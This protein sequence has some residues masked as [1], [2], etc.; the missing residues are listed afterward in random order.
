MKRHHRFFATLLAGLL[1]SNQA[2]AEK[3][4]AKKKPAPAP[5]VDRRNLTTPDDD[6]EPAPKKKTK[7]DQSDG[8]AELAVLPIKL[9]EIIEAAVQRAPDLAKAKTDRVVAAGEAGYAQRAQAWH[10]GGS[11]EYTRQSQADKTDVAPFATVGEDKLTATLQAGRRLPSGGEVSLQMQVIRDVTEI[12]VPSG[13]GSIYTGQESSDGTTATARKAHATALDATTPTVGDNGDIDHIYGAQAVAG[14]KFK[15]PLLRGLGSDV[16]L[17]DEHKAELGLAVATIKTQLTAEEMI[18]DI[19]HAYWELQYAAFEVETRAEALAMA[20]KQEAFTR[21][22]MRAGVATSTAL[23][24]VL[25]EI[26]TRDEAL[27]RARQALSKQSLDLRRKVGLEIDRRNIVM[28]PQEPVEIGPEEWDAEETIARAHQANRRL[29]TL[30]LQRKAA[31]IDIKVAKDQMLPQLDA[32]LQGGFLGA[33]RDAGG[34][35]NSLTQASGFQVMASLSFDIEASDAA[36][37]G[38]QAAVARKHKIDIDKEDLERQIDVEV[39]N[40]VE[41]VDLARKRVALADKAIVV[42]NDNSQAER[43]TFL[44]NH[45]NNLQVMQRQTQLIESQLKRGRAVADWRNAVCDLQF[46]SGVLLQQYGVSAIPH[47]DPHADR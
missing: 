47:A 5:A 12:N 27:L 15:Q 19:I 41:G 37:Q 36:K 21:E 38:H 8:P 32:T 22:E 16:A 28:R 45:S 42:A 10:L 14:L 1:F 40:A 34:A 11:L 20:Q 4:H 26:A 6:D 35:L 9:D 31:D 13:F 25:Y 29:V 24:T 7:R 3:H 23:N 44:A 46:L 18:K 30:G 39:A 43:L 33:G 2:L 17:A